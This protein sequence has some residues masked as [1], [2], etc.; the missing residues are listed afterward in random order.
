MA[1]KL[2]PLRGVDSL[3]KAIGLQTKFKNDYSG[4]KVVEDAFARRAAKEKEEKDLFSP[5]DVKI[6]T[7][8][9]E[10]YWA[11]KIQN[12]VAKYGSV[13]ARAKGLNKDNAFAIVQPAYAKMQTNIAGW[14][15]SNEEFSKYKTQGTGLYKNTDLITKVRTPGAKDE[16][17]LSFNEKIGNVQ[18]TPDGMFSYRPIKQYSKPVVFGEADYN[19]MPIEQVASPLPGYYQT[20]KGKV[21]TPQ[22]Y[23]NRIEQV[24]ADDEFEDS[25]IMEFPEL[26]N[27]D[28]NTRRAKVVEMAKAY[29]DAKMPPPTYDYRTE[30][31][32]TSSGSG[33][34]KDKREK[35]VIVEDTQQTLLISTGN[36]KEVKEGSKTVT[37]PERVQKNSPIPIST[38]IPNVPAVTIPL[39]K[40]VINANTN[41]YVEGEEL[42]Q[43]VTFKPDMV[44]SER[45]KNTGKWEKYVM[46]TATI[47]VEKQGDI[48]TQKVITYKMPYDK[49]QSAIEG[50]YD[51]TDFDEKFSTLAGGSAKPAAKQIKSSDISARAKA[52]G[53]T[54]QEYRKLLTEKGVKI[55]D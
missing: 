13:Y 5:L 3:G 36:M 31:I 42:N 53:Y 50:K 10:P 20:R 6:D 4:N 1:L 25:V 9:V 45:L 24:A 55:I 39:D 43:T 35:P 37:E 18:I 52:A 14:L 8:K 22:S 2:N 34:D 44:Y 38:A 48:V 21:V 17:I 27:A 12:E 54:D 49:L 19:E 23:Q 32:P 26:K 7:T 41:R 11:E 30:R 47:N 46:G 33:S 16:E 29:V 40:R 28:K 51:M 15:R